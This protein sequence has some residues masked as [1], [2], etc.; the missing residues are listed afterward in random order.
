MPKSFFKTTTAIAAL[1]SFS[2]PAVTAA[3][4][5]LD[6]LRLGDPSSRPLCPSGDLPRCPENTQLLT[7]GEL[8][9]QAMN[10]KEAKAF[11][12][13]N[14]VATCDDGASAV[15]PGGQGYEEALTKSLQEDAPEGVTADIGVA[16]GETALE[17]LVPNPVVPTEEAPVVS[18][19]TSEGASIL[20]VPIVEPEA[21]TPEPES[22][23]ETPLITSETQLPE[24]DE[25]DETA[26]AVLEG[27]LGDA[28][29]AAADEAPAVTAEAGPDGA[30][31]T[32]GDIVLST[33]DTPI[34]IPGL[35]ADEED[36]KS[37]LDQ[38]TG[39]VEPDTGAAIIPEALV[40]GEAEVEATTEVVVTEADTRQSNEDFA[41]SANANIA[42]V[43]PA[44][45][46][47]GRSDLEKAALVGL[48]ALAVGAILSNGDEVVTNSGDRVVVQRN[49]GEF[50]VLKDDDTLL[51]QP[52]SQVK[53]ES[54][55]DG[56]TRTTV[57]RED[58]SK[59]I[60][61]R[62]AA[63]RVVYRVRENTDGSRV[64]LIDDTANV[65]RVEVSTLPEPEVR[66]VRVIGDD[67]QTM[68]EAL[69]RAAA[70]GIDRYFSL[71]QI[72]EIE[73][74]R[75]LVP[76]IATDNVTFRTASAAIDPSEA[77]ELLEIGRIMTALIEANPS[78]IFL[79]EGHTDAVGNAAY[80]LAL[81]DRRAESVA[82][83]LT[84][85]FG[86][87]PENM[88]VQGYGESDLKIETQADE[89]LNRRVSVRRITPLLYQRL[90][91][92]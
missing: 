15:L 71:R 34:I 27:L 86:V 13:D 78:E 51:R 83:A 14:T 56:S 50:Y 18:V 84:E 66:E 63:G 11:C 62:D 72:R 92:N 12:S 25:A 48:G 57:E 53:T 5:A 29:D 52:G 10:Q 45:R 39:N 69:D 20:E 76:E 70:R 73:R 24:L 88:V 37:V 6:L 89:R 41:T 31:L 21:A 32:V 7:A 35:S 59:I 43:A 85:Y 2:F 33:D 47:G 22:A 9:L 79:I 19:E 49:D 28:N 4:D 42:E 36:V 60:T 44:T 8:L 38:L 17:I 90:A 87:R 80:N 3:Q 54:F 1:L 61:I 26:Q 68:R 82:L 40:G 81:S 55:N 74:V 91:R 64:A 67:V 75:K 16:A 23:V 46:G 58:G 30:E 77:E 65:E